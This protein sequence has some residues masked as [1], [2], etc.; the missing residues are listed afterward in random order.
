MTPATITPTLRACLLAMYQ[1]PDHTL[2]RTRGGFHVRGTPP[3]GPIFTLRAL[4]M[5]DR[6]WLLQFDNPAFPSTAQL[7]TKGAALAATLACA[8]PAGAT[9]A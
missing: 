8:Q 4:R 2:A 1:A 5:L 7:T 9:A 6:D 3:H